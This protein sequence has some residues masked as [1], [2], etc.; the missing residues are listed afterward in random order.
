MLLLI[1]YTHLCMDME[2]LYEM[3]LQYQAWFPRLDLRTYA[4]PVFRLFHAGY[5]LF[6]YRQSGLPCY[7]QIFP[8]FCGFSFVLFLLWKF[9]FVVPIFLV[10]QPKKIG[11]SRKKL[12][13]LRMHLKIEL[14]TF[15]FGGLIKDIAEVVGNEDIFPIGQRCDS[16]RNG[17]VR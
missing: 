10:G 1:F 4:L 17:H 9:S 15:S 14:P 3:L 8:I 12:G 6:A 7:P 5:G 2:R 11:N 13:K 16:C